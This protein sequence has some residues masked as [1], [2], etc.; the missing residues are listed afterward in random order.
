MTAGGGSLFMAAHDHRIGPGHFGRV[1]DY[2]VSADGSEGGPERFS[3]HYEADL[4]RGGRSVLDVRP[5]QWS[6]DGW[7]VAGD[8]V[9]EGTYQI[10]SRLS[11]NTLESHVP[12]A[13]PPPPA[14]G[15]PPPRGPVL[16]VPG[17]PIGPA[18]PRLWRYLALDNQKWTIA[19]AGGG[20]YKIVNAGSGDALGE[21]EVKGTGMPP[22]TLAA[23]TGAD[24]QMWRLDQFPDGGWRIV[25]KADGLSLNSGSGGMMLDK[26]KR[27]DMHLWTITTP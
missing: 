8:N 6:L 18:A 13:P 17:T 15:T 5:L 12:T 24:K 3:V 9:A 21:G 11:E 2:D 26:F 16:D 10:V 25:N 19:P 14:P 1:L 27:D 20:F 4:T 23:Y 7:P 22:V